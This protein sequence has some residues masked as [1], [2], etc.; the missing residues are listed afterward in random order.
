MRGLRNSF[1]NVAIFL[2]VWQGIVRLVVHMI[3]RPWVD[4]QKED[5]MS[6]AFFQCSRLII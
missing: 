5:Y 2:A 3:R 4:S 6:S 1:L